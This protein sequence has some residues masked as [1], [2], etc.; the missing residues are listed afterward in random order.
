MINLYDL[1]LNTFQEHKTN[2]NHIHN[3]DNLI[4]VIQLRNK[5][6]EIEEYKAQIEELLL[7]NDL[8]NDYLSK[9]NKKYNTELTE[10]DVETGEEICLNC[11]NIDDE[12]LKLLCS[13]NFK[14]IKVL[15][16]SDNNITNIDSFVSAPFRQLKELYLFG[17]NISNI[18]ALEKFPFKT[19]EKLS[20]GANMIEDISVFSKVPFRKLRVLE[21]WENNISNIDALG[22]V[23]F[24][25]LKELNLSSNKISDLKALEHVSLRRLE[26]LSLHDNLINNIDVLTEIQFKRVQRLYLE[27]NKVDYNLEHN[28]KIIEELKK[29][30][31]DIK[32]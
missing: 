8:Q 21:L 9:L 14:S 27:N 6:K 28:K 4:E 15:H 18:E 22:S 2:Y 3:I 19:L 1:V 29:A 12:G 25:R 17:N 31:R 23:P 11:K 10:Q 13:I 7:R 5:D 26:K 24:K 20:L 32:Y 16:L 30:D